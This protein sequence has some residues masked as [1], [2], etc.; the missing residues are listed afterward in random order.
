[1]E[2]LKA[3]GVDSRSFFYPVSEQ[4]V[5]EGDDPRFPDR[6]GSR[7]V[8]SNLGRRGLYLP[9]GIGLT[10]AQIKICAEALMSLKR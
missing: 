5:F 7:P 9:S 10:D 1:M 8:S 2:G 3:R 4:P 6:T